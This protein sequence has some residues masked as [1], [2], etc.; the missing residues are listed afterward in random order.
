MVLVYLKTS[1]CI[2]VEDAFSAERRGGL[3]VCLDRTGS[4]TASFQLGDI[5]SF[6]TNDRMA[7]AMKE[8]V[9]ED[10]TVIESG[11]VVEEPDTASDL[12]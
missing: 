6:T 2:E 7:E 5:E 8:E 3:L 12:A 1:E 10:L 4:V 9:C 11:E